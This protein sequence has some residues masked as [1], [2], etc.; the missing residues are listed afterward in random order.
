[1]IKNANNNQ[2]DSA[3]V[4]VEPIF[5][6]ASPTKR[7][8]YIDYLR[9][10]A[11][12]IVLIFHAREILWIGFSKAWN[13]MGLHAPIGTWLGYLTLPFSF[14]RSAVMLFFVISGFCLYKSY[15]SLVTREP[16]ISRRLTVFMGRRIVRIVPVL[17]VAL[18]MTLAL[19]H[20]TRMLTPESEKLGDNSYFCMVA[21]L[22]SL[23]NIIAPT[24]GSNSALWSLSI[25]EHLYALLPILFFIRRRMG[26]IKSAGLFVCISI[27]A[28][29]AGRVSPNLTLDFLPYL[30]CWTFGFLLTDPIEQ[31]RSLSV[32]WVV[33]ILGVTL[34]LL[35]SRLFPG[36]GGDITISAGF[37]ALLLIA[38]R[39]PAQT[40]YKIPGRS[41]LLFLGDISF[42]LYATHIP[43]LLLYRSS[44]MNDEQSPEMFHAIAACAIA[45]LIAWL[46]HIS[47]ERPCLAALE[48]WR[49]LNVKGASK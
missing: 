1:M 3:S 48:K 14:G 8:L 4:N 12:T 26:A 40:W 37:T 22:L 30:A 11:A 36:L 38:G 44:I 28:V 7:M 35:Q 41:G 19:D 9:G 49:F 5:R 32:F 33:A 39:I 21:N 6:M 17:I 43:L 13:E 16:I 34:G 25:E 46:I 45:I 47:I 18:V 23:Q 24:Y 15:A 27:A 29:V 31:E 2:L 20:F 42:P 10:I